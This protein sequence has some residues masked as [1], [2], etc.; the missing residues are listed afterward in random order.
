MA[1]D[2]G[3]LFLVVRLGSQLAALPVSDVSE[4]FRP[5]PIEPI[6]N[7]PHGVLGASIVRGAPMPVVDLALIVAG[8][9]RP[10]TPFVVV[11]AGGRHVAVAVEPVVGVRALSESDRAAL[12]PLLASESSAVRAL[13]ALDS[14]LNLVLEAGRLLQGDAERA[15]GVE[16]TP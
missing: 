4:T 15:S 3:A 16:A 6:A 1:T 12:P 8:T 14:E 13:G 10:A 7:A 5:I 9:S 2:G 11:K